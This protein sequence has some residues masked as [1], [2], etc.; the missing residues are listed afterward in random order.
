MEVREKKKAKSRK[1]IRSRGNGLRAKQKTI[2]HLQNPKHPFSKSSPR[3]D[4]KYKPLCLLRRPWPFINLPT[5]HVTVPSPLGPTFLQPNARHS[6]ILSSALRERTGAGGASGCCAPCSRCPRRAS[7][8]SH[9]R[10]VSA[11]AAATYGGG[12]C[13]SRTRSTSVGS[14]LAARG[15]AGGGAAD[16][17]RGAASGCV[18]SLFFVG[19]VAT[20][21][22][23]AEGSAVVVALPARGSGGGGSGRRTAGVTDA[24]FQVGDARV[25][26]G[27]PHRRRG[28]PAVTFCAKHFRLSLSPL[29]LPGRFCSRSVMHARSRSR[30]AGLYGS[31]TRQDN[32]L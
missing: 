5:L 6:K 32:A 31:A 26:N 20:T 28:R 1:R 30:P 17:E 3:D 27:W 29:S 4:H 14:A 10:C 7:T 25:P 23:M 24:I 15:D 12:S 21:V 9:S 13:T 19:L 22:P 2:Q 11:L 16:G 8:L 18:C